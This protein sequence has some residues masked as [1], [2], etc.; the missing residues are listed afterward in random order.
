MMLIESKTFEGNVF[1]ELTDNG[2]PVTLFT[3][4]ITSWLNEVSDDCSS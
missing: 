1:D 2:P 3:E 4:H